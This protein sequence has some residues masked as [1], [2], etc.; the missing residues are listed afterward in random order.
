[1][2]PEPELMGQPTELKPENTVTPYV[3]ALSRG[4]WEELQMSR[5]ELAH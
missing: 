2:V 1:M 4:E 3:A 5:P